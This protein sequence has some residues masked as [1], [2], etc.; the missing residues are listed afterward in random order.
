MPAI[1]NNTCTVYTHVR[2]C[3]WMRCTYTLVQHQFKTLNTVTYTICITYIPH[4]PPGPP[5]DPLRWLLSSSG[6]F[7]PFSPFKWLAF[8][9]YC[10]S[11]SLHAQQRQQHVAL[12][13][14]VQSGGTHA[15][16]KVVCKTVLLPCSLPKTIDSLLMDLHLS[17]L[18]TGLHPYGVVSRTPTPLHTLQTHTLAISCALAGTCR[19]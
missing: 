18:Q 9:P 11:H 15:E 1:I 16:E 3:S 10:P 7:P 4:T 2:T 19:Q 8:W 13:R 14:L 17:C 6:I 12:P 5:I